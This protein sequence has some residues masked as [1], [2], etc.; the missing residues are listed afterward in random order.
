MMMMMVVVVM[1]LPPAV[2]ALLGLPIYPPAHL[3]FLSDARKHGGNGREDT[4][5]RS[6]G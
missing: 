4:T 6:N 2:S 3:A 5:V 1:H